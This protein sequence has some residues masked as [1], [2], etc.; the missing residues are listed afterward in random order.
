VSDTAVT[1]LG[2]IAVATAVMAVIQVVVIVGLAL[3][4]RKLASQVHRAVE[5]LED[6]LRRLEA[7]SDP[8]LDTLT[9]VGT[10]VSHAA[11][12]ARAQAEKIDQLTTNVSRRVDRTLDRAQRA[13][14]VPAREGIALGA[15]VKATLGSLR[16][17]RLERQVERRAARQ[18]RD[19]EQA[20][21]IG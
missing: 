10:D 21:F 15:A 4:G 13:L 18:A 12:L 9:S 3:Y 17:Q 8:I 7:R 11:S 14:T 1:F 20:L 5:R 19:D 16:E 6:A 2:T